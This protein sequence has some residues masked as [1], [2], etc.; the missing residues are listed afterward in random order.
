[1]TDI[2]KIRKGIA[3][4]ENLTILSGETGSTI[5]YWIGV[6]EELKVL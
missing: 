5:S 3:P 1:M 2:N 4:S 6:I